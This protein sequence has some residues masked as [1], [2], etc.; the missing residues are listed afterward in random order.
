MNQ[1]IIKNELGKTVWNIDYH[2]Q[3]LAK[4]K[5]LKEVYEAQLLAIISK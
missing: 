4:Y 2:Q 5:A 3:E 1:E